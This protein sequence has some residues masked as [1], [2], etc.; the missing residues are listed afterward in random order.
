MAEQGEM[1]QV[2]PVE[3]PQETEEPAAAEMTGPP[4]GWT[5]TADAEPHTAFTQQ[6]ADN[7]RTYKCTKCI[8]VA[9]SYIISIVQNLMV[10]IC[11]CFSVNISYY[12]YSYRAKL[13]L[14]KK[15]E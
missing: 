8:L 1:S 4:G 10:Y 9:F 11:M 15:L 14:K 13:M 3:Q 6:I 12:Y 2:D 5:D 7:V